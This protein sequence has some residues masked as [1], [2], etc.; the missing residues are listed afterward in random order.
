MADQLPDSSE[1][2]HQ[3]EAAGNS[4]INLHLPGT[5]TS[6]PLWASIPQQRG[7]SGGQ[8]PFLAKLA[9]EEYRGGTGHL[10]MM[11]NQ[12]GCCLFQ[13]MHKPSQDEWG[14][15]P[16]AAEATMLL[17]KNLGQALWDLHAQVSPHTDACHCAFPESHSLG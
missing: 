3:V 17:E 7:D 6:L 11:Q 13:E 10:L 4:L 16:D 2:F 5:Y 8:H 9:K 15:A 1:L 14:A 12:L